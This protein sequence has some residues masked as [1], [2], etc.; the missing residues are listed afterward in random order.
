M[1][2]STN[3]G[4]TTFIDSTGEITKSTPLMKADIL[5]AEIPK[6]P[7]LRSPFMALAAFFGAA[8]FQ[9]LCQLLTLLMIGAAVQSSRKQRK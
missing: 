3:T 9:H 7:P 4:F 2:R 8:W 6:R 5:Q 1:F